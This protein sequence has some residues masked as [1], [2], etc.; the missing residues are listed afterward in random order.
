MTVEAEILMTAIHHELHQAEHLLHLGPDLLLVP[1]FAGQLL[2]VAQTLQLAG[3]IL[4]QAA[5]S[6]LQLLRYLSLN[7]G[8]FPARTNILVD[9][10]AH[11]YPMTRSKLWNQTELYCF[12]EHGLW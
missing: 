8:N 5:Q 4:P 12:L 9:I 2:L 7:P 10:I 11:S 3:Y 1:A 6:L